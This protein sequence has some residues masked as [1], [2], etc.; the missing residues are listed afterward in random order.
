MSVP[1]VAYLVEQCWHRVPGG[2]AVA[3]AEIANALIQRSDIELKGIAARHKIPP[4]VQLPE[5]LHVNHSKLPRQLLYSFWQS[6]NRP[7]VETLI[8]DV[9]LVHASGGAIPPTQLP[10][11][12]TIYD[13]SWRH[14]PSWFP[15]RGRHFAE[16]WLQKSYRAD[17][18][19]CPSQTTRLDLIEVGF[20]SKKIRVVPLGVRQR[21]VENQS[22]QF[23]RQ[24]YDLEGS[25]V[26]WMGT[27]EPRK[28]LPTLIEA[29]SKIPKVNLV[30]V[31][32]TGWNADVEEI[33]RPIKDRVRVI[34]KVDE[35]TK[36][37]WLEAADVFCFPS[38]FE[39][40][41]LPVVEAMSHGTPVVT[42]ATTATAEVAADSGLLIDPQKSEEIAEAILKILE[43]RDLSQELSE[44]GRERSKKFSWENS[45]ELIVKAYKEVVS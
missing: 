1:R 22:V 38:L 16:E 13:L 30:L 41:G 26:L 3:T 5:D 44:C 15:S 6:L 36:H 33:T 28:N 31:G 14:D 39:G 25:F 27:V 35:E 19:I 7:R 42:S 8:E 20:D 34:G 37:V 21:K 45:A 23:L 29:I 40:F 24:K 12:S 18:V 32:P 4:D 2:T 43:N 9:D 17:L 10:L 11:I